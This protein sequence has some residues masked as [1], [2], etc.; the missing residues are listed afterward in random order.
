MIIKCD[1]SW[2]CVLSYLHCITPLL[3]V[4]VTFPHPN[5]LTKNSGVPQTIVDPQY[6]KMHNFHK[7]TKKEL[8]YLHLRFE[9]IRKTLIVTHGLNAYL[10]VILAP[11]MIASDAKTEI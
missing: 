10:C 11:V 5:P 3:E 4:E 1:F 2:Y 8:L 7:E 6:T 9:D